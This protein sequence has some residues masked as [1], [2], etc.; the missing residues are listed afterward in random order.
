MAVTADVRLRLEPPIESALY[1][2]IVELVTNTAKHARAPRAQ[3]AITREGARLVVDVE[4]DGRGGATA[5]AGGGLPGLRQRLAVFDGTLEI[6]GPA[7]GPTRA[8]IVVPCES[9]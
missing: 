9:L 5:R 6:A 7:G 3:I 2:G 8:R 1:F 4:H